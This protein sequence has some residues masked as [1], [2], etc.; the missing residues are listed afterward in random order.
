MGVRRCET[1]AGVREELVA[2]AI[3]DN[4]VRAVLLGAGRRQNVP[5]ARIRFVDAPRWLTSSSPGT[6]LS[7][8]VV[9]PARKDRV[10]P[11]CQKR[12]AKKYPYVTRP[13]AELRQQRLA[14]EVPAELNGIRVVPRSW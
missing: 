5:V 1:E 11:R 4:L 2:F 9:S 10:E 6:P 14:Q 8:V 12:R 3:A 7:D 13:R